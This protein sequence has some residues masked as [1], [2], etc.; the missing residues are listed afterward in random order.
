MF[1]GHASGFITDAEFLLLHQENSSDN[2]DFPYDNYPRFSLQDQSEPDCKANFWL[3]KHHIGRLVDVP[4]IP[5]IFKCDQGTICE[6]LEGLCIMLKRFAF[7]CRFSDMIP[8]LERPVPELCMINNTVIDW[9]YNH[10]RHRIIDWNPNVLSPIQLKN[11]SEAVFN[12]GAALSSGTQRQFLENT[13]SEGDLRSRI[14]G[15]FVVKFLVCLPLLGF[16]NI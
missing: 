6:G 16:S 4:Q 15:T 7:L 8:I 3:E 5:A 1:I 14:F 2:L 11:Y 12:K 9:V 10:H 13:C